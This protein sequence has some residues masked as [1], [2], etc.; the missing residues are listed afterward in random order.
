MLKHITQILLAWLVFV[1]LNSFSK[2]HSPRSFSN[3]VGDSDEVFV[4]KEF[5]DFPDSGCVFKGNL[6]IGETTKPEECGYKNTIE[7]AKKKAR[8]AGGNIVRITSLKEPND[9]NA[10]FRL[11][12]DIYYSEDP[13][14]VIAK[15]VSVQDSI[16][17]SKFPENPQYALLYLYNKNAAFGDS[18]MDLDIYDENTKI[19]TV[20]NSSKYAIKLYEEGE[21]KI[22]F[23]SEKSD[24]V[25]I[26]VKFGQEYFMEFGLSS[27]VGTGL[28][29]GTV[30][31]TLMQSSILRFRYKERGRKEFQNLESKE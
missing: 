6:K 7:K 29:Y 14:A 31:T 1:L 28:M 19:A 10:C 16:T 18:F 3:P 13:K 27:R 11:K 5:Q 24:S 25:K 2:I 20:R 9:G 30:G 8:K 21:R 23:N 15:M 17:K 22:W 4:V 12:A 26:D